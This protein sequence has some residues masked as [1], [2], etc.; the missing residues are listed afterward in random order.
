MALTANLT[1]ALFGILSSNAAEFLHAVK[2]VVGPVMAI[3]SATSMLTHQLKLIIIHEDG[4]LFLLDNA[5]QKK[6]KFYGLYVFFPQEPADQIA[7]K[8]SRFGVS[9]FVCEGKPS[10]FTKVCP[11]PDK[12]TPLQAFKSRPVNTGDD[13]A[14]FP[15]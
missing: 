12:P 14:W 8:C 13:P 4:S 10:L 5:V 2:P 1:S 15:S 11:L 7:T 3:K 6:F 9:E